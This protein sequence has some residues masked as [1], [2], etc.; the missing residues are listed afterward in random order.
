MQFYQK[1]MKQLATTHPA[2]RFFWPRQVDI[3]D[4][5]HLFLI[6]LSIVAR[7]LPP[8]SEMAL[9][10]CLCL[11]F[12]QSTALDGFLSHPTYIS[13]MDFSVVTGASY[14]FLVCYLQ[15]FDFNC[16]VTFRVEQ[17]S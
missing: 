5:S 6:L 2:L 9:W 12:N 16:R 4:L 14:R 8:N 17:S 7:Y 11:L 1:T 3:D 13:E 15:H 10:S